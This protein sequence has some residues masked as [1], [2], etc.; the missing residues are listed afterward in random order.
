MIAPGVPTTVA[1]PIAH[2]EGN[3]VAMARAV[4]RQT[5][6]ARYDAGPAG[7]F[8]PAAAFDV[9]DLDPRKVATMT[10]AVAQLDT[11]IARA[12]HSRSVRTAIRQDARSVP[13]MVRFAD[14]PMPWQA[15]RPAISLYDALANDARL[16]DTL[17]SAAASASEAVGDTVLAHRE[18]GEFAPFGGADYGDAAGPTVHF[19]LTPRQVDTWA[20]AVSETDNAFYAKVGANRVARALA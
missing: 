18:A 9:I 4:V 19:P 11:E 3:A 20:P 14:E 6:S 5:M 1:S 15:D 16:P 8:G 2:H 7:E 13:G 10:R 17:R 12:A